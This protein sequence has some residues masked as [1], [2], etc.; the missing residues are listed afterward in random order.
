M[1]SLLVN[2][3]EYPSPKESSP[4]CLGLFRALTWTPGRIMQEWSWLLGIGDISNGSGNAPLAQHVVRKLVEVR[5]DTRSSSPQES[6]H[7]WQTP[8]NPILPHQSE[9]LIHDPPDWQSR[10]SPVGGYSKSLLTRLLFVIWGL[11]DNSMRLLPGFSG[12]TSPMMTTWMYSCS[13]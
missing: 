4:C 12:S 5:S 6:Y 2:E 7:P 1:S 10:P 11:M 8:Q 3:P 13:L 9:R